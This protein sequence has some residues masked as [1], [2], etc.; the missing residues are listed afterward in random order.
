MKNIYADK[1]IEP[2][3]SGHEPTML[4]LHQSA[5]SKKI[6]FLPSRVGH[7]PTSFFLTRKCSTN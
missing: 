5:F 2:L 4:P 1:G 7:D 6:V 3:Y